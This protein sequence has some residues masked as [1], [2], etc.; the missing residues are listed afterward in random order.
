MG[1]NSLVASTPVPMN[2]KN[3]T[4]LQTQVPTSN[5]L[6]PLLEMRQIS[7]RFT[8]T[9]A[10]DNVDFDVRRGEVHAL[11]GQNG[12]GKSTLIKIL[13]GVY[14]ASGGE[15]SYAGSVVNPMAQRLSISFIHQDLGLVDS[16]TVAENVA[17]AAG[18][19]KR[20]GLI[21]WSATR[22]SGEQ[23][24]RLMGSN[25][26]PTLRV[27]KLAAA[28]KSLVA[29]ARAMAIKAD[30]LV[31]DEPTAA[32]PEVDVARLLDALDQLRKKGIG[33]IY[34]SHRLD[35]VFRIADR[36]TILRDGKKVRTAATS[37]IS[38]EQLVFDIVGRAL[39][40]SFSPS[41]L[42]AVDPVLQVNDLEAGMAGPVSFTVSAG[43][44]LGLVGLRGSGHDTVGRAIF[45]DI[46]VE[47]GQ[48]LLGSRQLNIK[49]SK[50]AMDEGI[51]FVSSKRAEENITANMTV[52]ENLFLNPLLT[53]TAL[54]GAI[55]P[56]AEA[57]S[58]QTLISR[59]SIRPADPERPMA[60]L[61]GG[62][63][64]KVIIARWLQAGIRILI[65]EEP[66]IGVDVGS[67]AEI[68]GLLQSALS[69]GMAVLLISSD[70]EEIE[71]ICHRALVFDRGKINAEVTRDQL[72]VPYLT[73]LAAGQPAVSSGKM[74]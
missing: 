66:T 59:F 32:L 62:N 38:P 46:P 2:Q 18:Y 63:Q 11:L 61:S 69:E 20:F 74:K 15:I 53:G 19:K 35:E 68:Y 4:I 8:G 65:L 31:L 1:S 48:V 17:I 67:K 25:V 42:G 71:R 9:L 29:I 45:G 5:V 41:R 57:T 33:I 36:V 37:D 3:E 27:G 13:A 54:L 16:M 12:A 28:D 73:M 22:N 21:S 7:K 6:A 26:D 52:R 60:T 56:K 24:L 30:L 58:S 50:D 43:E 47:R 70:F 64:Q 49:T 23:A 44:I 10:L 34:V 51:G 14:A 39:D 55:H 40:R 72:K